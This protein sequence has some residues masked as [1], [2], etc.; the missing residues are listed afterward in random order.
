MKKKFDCVKFQREARRKL[1]ARYPES[2]NA[3]L[4]RMLEEKYGHLRKRKALHLAGR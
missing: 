3:E 1:S 4:S 2:R